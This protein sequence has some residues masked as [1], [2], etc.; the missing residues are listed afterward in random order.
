MSADYEPGRQQNLRVGTQKPTRHPCHTAAR[1]G[2]RLSRR[3]ASVRPLC[4]NSRAGDAPMWK[5]TRLARMVLPM[6]ALVSFAATASAA[7]PDKPVWWIVPYAVG[8]GADV[9]SRLLAN[10]LSERLN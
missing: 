10:R 5:L 6:L 4:S 2:P 7:Y 8:G 9:I 1:Y 3:R